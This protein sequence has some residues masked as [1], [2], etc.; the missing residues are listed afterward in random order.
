MR[1]AGFYT[2]V[3]RAGDGI[4]TR[5]IQHGKLMLYQ[6]SY[7]RKRSAFNEPPGGVKGAIFIFSG[8][9]VEDRGGLLTRS[10]LG[11]Y[12]DLQGAV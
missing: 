8:G 2:G 10:S 3:S 1:N 11:V 4:R 9:M 12:G 7:S 5:D 6:L